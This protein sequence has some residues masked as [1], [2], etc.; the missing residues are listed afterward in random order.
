MSIPRAVRKQAREAERLQQQV[1]D[2]DDQEKGVNPPVPPPDPSVEPQPPAPAPVDWEKRWKGL[3]A[4][5]DETVTELRS[6][7]E[8]LTSELAELRSLVEKTTQTTPAAQETP[9]FT[10]EEKEKFGEDFL[11][12]VE[13]VAGNATAGTGTEEIA[14]ELKELKDGFTQI[15]ETQVKTSEERF[16]DS[17]DELVPDWE[18]INEQDGFKDWLKEEMPLTGIERQH[19]LNIAR[20]NFDARR[21]AEIFSSWKGG[22][23]LPQP[24]LDTVGNANSDIPTRDTGQDTHV[25]SAAEIADFYDQ[26]RRGKWNGREQEA[27][28][29]EERIFKAQQ[30]GRVRA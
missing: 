23:D 26:K 28:Q 19:F 3:K 25:F 10:E 9:L 17:L 2:Q 4:S 5:H 21:A 18:S 29:H 14:Q 13:R 15:Q 22:A 7:N 12:L 1:V 24:S 27:R 8:N 6:Q 16:F 20:N 30:E 11:S